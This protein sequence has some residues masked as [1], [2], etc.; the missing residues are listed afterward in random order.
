[1]FVLTEMRDNIRIDPTWFDE[2]TGERIKYELNKK[3]ANKVVYGVGLCI[4]LHDIIQLGDSYIFPGDGAAHMKVVFR[5]VVFRPFI[6]EVLVGKVRSSSAEGV[7]VSLTFFDDIIIP[8][9]SLQ[10]PKRF[11]H[12]EQ[13]W[14]W[15][16]QTEDGNHDLF[17]DSGEEIRFR[18]VEEQFVD[19]IPT[20]VQPHISAA[21]IPGVTPPI[22]EPKDAPY[23]IIGSIS[24]SGLG[25]LSWWGSS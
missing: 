23:T 18:V 20:D 19:T 15:E 21:A 8:P 1:M 7:T 13:L 2:D 25:L 11:D 4:T 9:Q 22:S 3:F 14:V 24:E 12:K 17:M 10:H 6:N 5:F 16:Y